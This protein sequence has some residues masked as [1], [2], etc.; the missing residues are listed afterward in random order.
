MQLA[1]L[2][3][4]DA[5][6]EAAGNWQ[7]FTCFWWQRKSEI[8]DPENWAIIYTQQSRQRPARSKQC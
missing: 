5:A 4:E 1:S 6:K 7:D 3:I 8:E 2:S